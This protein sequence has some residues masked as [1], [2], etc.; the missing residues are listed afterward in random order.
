[1]CV[2]VCEGEEHVHLRELGLI[3][4]LRKEFSKWKVCVVFP[5]LFWGGEVLFASSSMKK[6]K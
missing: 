3:Y 4:E 5:F 1:V 2:C 6:L